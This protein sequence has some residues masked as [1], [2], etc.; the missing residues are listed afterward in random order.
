MKTH[1]MLAAI[2]A[3][4]AGHA[5]AEDVVVYSARAE[6]LVKPIIEAYKKETGVNIKLVSDK[7]G[8]LM[9]RLRAEGGNSPADLLLTVDAGNL[10]QAAKM[11]LLKPVKSPLLDA[12][13]PSYLRD[14]GNEWYG[15]SIRARTIFYNTQKVKPGQLSSYADLADPKWKGKLC[16]R[17]SKKVYNQSLV[18]M[19]LADLGPAKTEKVVKGWVDNLATREFP[20]DTKMLEA[21]AAGQC[22]VGIANT[23]YYGRLMEKSPKLPLGIFW[24]DQAGKGTHVNISGAGVVK[25]AKNE[26]GALKFLEWLSSAKAQNMFADVNMEFPVNP[27]VKPDASVAAW[28]E[29]KHSYINVANAGARQAEAV[30]LMDRVGYK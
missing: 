13:I 23:Y 24:A 15:L 28:G 30:K 27:K 11:G 5:M 6:Q 18:A 21:I 10:W 19:M 2:L 26:K 29:F 22:E 14:P 8:P 9:E 4:F 16:L 25:H 20:D 17:T 1:L 7:E 12:N 3:G